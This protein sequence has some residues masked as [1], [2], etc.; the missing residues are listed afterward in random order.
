MS[1]L[2][3]KETRAIVQGATGRIGRKQT[4]WMLEYGT[5]IVAGVTPGHGGEVLEDLGAIPVYDCVSEAVAEQGANASV[6]FV[7]APLVKNA[8]LESVDAGIDLIVS[9]PEHVPVHDTLKMRYSTR[10]KGMILIGPNTPGVIS[11]GIGKLGIMPG[12]MFTQGR[13]GL[14]S[15]SGTLAYEVAGYLNEAGYGQSTV[16]GMGGDPVVGTSLGE[17]LGMF[18]QDPETDAVV[19]VGEIG[20]TAE[21]NAA[22]QIARMKKRVVSFMAGRSAPDGRTLGH[23]GAI[24][25]G[26]SGTIEYKTKCLEEAGAKVASAI[27][28]I[29]LLLK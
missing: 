9:V 21:E 17:I 15:R 14:I 1:I 16:V 3:T 25:R 12:N 27:A 13:V 20:G 5:K 11:P 29:C 8:V 23:A 7:P 2:L 10:D 22:P 4:G 26:R 6:L 28:E 19:V 18:E 24:I